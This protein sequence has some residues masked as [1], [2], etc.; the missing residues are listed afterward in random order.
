[1]RCAS[2]II[3]SCQGKPH[4]DAYAR[5]RAE[6]NVSEPVDTVT[7][8]AEEPVGIEVVGTVPVVNPIGLTTEAES[9]NPSVP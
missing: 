2:T 6:G 4:A 3:A 9:R 7:I 1:M 8:G 5:P